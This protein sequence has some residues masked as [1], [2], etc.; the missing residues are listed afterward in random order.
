M[1]IGS[2]SG[3]WMGGR[4]SGLPENLEDQLAD[5]RR[6]QL[7]TPI[8][9]DISEA[10]SLKKT[11]TNF[12]SNISQLVQ[13]LD[14]MTEADTFDVSSATSSDADAVGV[15]ADSDATKGTYDLDVT[16]LA[17]AQ[18][19]QVGVDSGLSD[20]DDAALV[21]DDMQVSFFH[22]GEE[23]SYTT[24]GESTL[25]SLA[26][27][28]NDDANGVR[29]TVNN[30][31]TSDSPE[32]AL[33]L[34]SETTG[35]ESQLITTDGSTD[36]SNLGVQITDTTASGRTNLFEV[37]AFSQST[38]QQGQ[39]ASFSVDG[40]AYERASNEVADVIQ[41][42]TLD[43]QTTGS[44]IRVTVQ[45]D[46][47][48]VTSS[49]QNFVKAFNA[50]RGYIDQQTNYNP[51]TGESGALQGSSIA[52]S[53]ERKMVNAIH[54]QVGGSDATFS[55]LSEI[56]IE[57]QR[58]GSLSFDAD[59][60]GSAFNDDPQAVQDMF[61]GE[62]GF[63]E[64]LKSQMTS[65]TDKYDGLLTYKI[66]SVGN[67]L[68]DLNDELDDAETSVQDYLERMVQKYTAMENAISGYKSMEGA[69]ES[70]NDT[71]KAMNEG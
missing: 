64:T 2:V 60:F 3:F 27:A 62:T 40:V 71:F 10:E 44:D 33:I 45:R 52:N 21:A 63:A 39:N 57:I 4:P 35:G 29:A 15:T 58:D 65:Y 31:G 19:Q 32:Y 37:G 54:S 53:I 5:A 66:E 56:G 70:M 24:D 46:M 34:K 7:V 43:L 36:G 17:Q 14:P 18:T 6:Q 16:H 55:Y 69:I 49:V 22:G 25:Q 1:P 13:Y 8:K 30:V 41:G 67:Q 48:A 51:E 38:T 47:E 28:I 9:E 23:Y 20:A 50:S 26:T 68:T 61:V 11:L 42:V 12:S 59:K